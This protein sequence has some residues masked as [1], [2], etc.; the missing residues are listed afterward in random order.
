MPRLRQDQLVGATLAFPHWPWRER[1]LPPGR[2]AAATW[3]LDAAAVELE[4]RA[5]PA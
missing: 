5:V 1:S 4:Q 3:P 2:D